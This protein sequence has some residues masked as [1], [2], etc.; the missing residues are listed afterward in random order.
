VLDEA[1]KNVLIAFQS[2]YRQ[3]KF[4]GM[5]DAQTAAMLDVLTANT[6]TR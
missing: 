1:T 5:P 6:K 3:E 2:K 4:D